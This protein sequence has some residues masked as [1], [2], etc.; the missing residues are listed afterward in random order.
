MARRLTVAGSMFGLDHESIEANE[1][2]KATFNGE[3]ILSNDQP[4]NL[5]DMEW[6]WGGECRLELD[7]DAYLLDNQDIRVV[8]T[9]KLY[10][11]ASEESGDLDGQ[12]DFIVI[13]PRGK[14]AYHSQRVKNDR[15]GG[16]YADYKLTFHNSLAGG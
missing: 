14:S 3:K 4:Q 2:R 15:E 11:G 6:G 13:I 8:G 1:F 5:I 16:D 12:R 7:L 9:A 10:E